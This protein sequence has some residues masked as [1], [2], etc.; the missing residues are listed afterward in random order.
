MLFSTDAFD[1]TATIEVPLPEVTDAC[2]TVGEILTEV[3]AIEEVIEGDDTTENL[4]L[5]AT[6]PFD[7]TD[8]TLTGLEQGDYYFRYTA[9]DEC[10]NTTEQLCRFRVADLEVPIAICQGSLNISLGSS[11]LARAYVHH[12]DFGSYD[13]CEVVSREVRRKYMIDPV[14]GEPLDEPVYSEWGPYVTFDCMDAGQL[15]EVELRITDAA[16]NEAICWSDYLIED[17]VAPICG[18]LADTEVNCNELPDDFDATDAEQLTAQFGEAIVIDNCSAT[19]EELAPRITATDGSICLIERR[20]LATDASGNVSR[21]TFTQVVTIVN[22]SGCSIC[23]ETNAIVEGPRGINSPYRN[24][25]E[26]LPSTKRDGLVLMQNFPN[27]VFGETVIGFELPESGEATIRVFT[28]TG[29][30]IKVVEGDYYQ[31]YNSVR[32]IREDLPKAPG[33]LYYQLDFK[34]V[35]VTRQMLIIE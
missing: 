9:A 27:P 5:V 26:T 33:I 4:V 30:L 34:G 14:T 1:C 20:F 15:V 18:G 32:L 10:G 29:R 7:A 6:I 17:K 25:P 31:G 21:D 13:N 12:V 8:R 16:G 3:L 23:E 22:E 19:I 28:K 35:Q 24:R 11:G 2:S